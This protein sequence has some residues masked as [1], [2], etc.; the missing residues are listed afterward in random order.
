MKK[1]FILSL[2]LIF[3]FSFIYAVNY[4]GTQNAVDSLNS[5][6][7]EIK[8]AG[9]EY[10]KQE[11]T[12]I[13]E[14]NDFGKIILAIGDFLTAINPIFKITIVV[15]Y[16]LSWYFLFSFLVWIILFIFFFNLGR[17]ILY[18]KSIL[19]LILSFILTSLIGIGGGVREI[20]DL[21]AYL[22]KDVWIAS[23]AFISVLVIIFLL[24]KFGDAFSERVRK[25]V[26][27]F[28]KDA[29]EN[30]REII[31]STAEGLREGLLNDDKK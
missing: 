19:V 20:T 8:D 23:L 11:W 21:F 26:E 18:G 25:L 10:L 29:I 7:D 16:S 14:R 17:G 13:L 9:A 30:D 12:K 22:I 31:H 1:L 6:P 28:E 15:D 5:N 2:I 24:S 27:Q 3:L 4:S